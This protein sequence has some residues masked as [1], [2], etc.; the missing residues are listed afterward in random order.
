MS[1]LFFIHFKLGHFVL[2][3]FFHGHPVDIN[4]LIFNKFAQLFFGMF[5]K[6]QS[7]SPRYLLHLRDLATLLILRA[8]LPIHVGNLVVQCSPANNTELQCKFLCSNFIRSRGESST[9][10]SHSQALRF[11]NYDKTQLKTKVCP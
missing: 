6:K 9:R 7:E 11:L 10:K 2:A 3:Q 4:V 8:C 5:C 1:Q